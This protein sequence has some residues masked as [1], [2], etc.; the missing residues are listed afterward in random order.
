MESEQHGTEATTTE[1]GTAEVHDLSA[2][3]D[4]EQ[5][6]D[7]TSEDDTTGEAGAESPKNAKPVKF[8]DLAEA[9]GLEL[10]DLYKLEL[11][12]GDGETIT[13]EE[14]KALKG[15]QDDLTVRQLEIEEDHATKSADLRKAQN[16][17]AEI[18]A[19]LPEGSV[20][21][22]TL[23]KVRERQAAR[24]EIEQRKMLESIPSWSDADARAG[25]LAGMAQH[26][27]SFGFPPDHL[28]NVID[29]R[30]MVFVRESY[31]REQRIRKALE[32]VRAGAPNP[33]T[34][35]KAAKT[36]GKAKAAPKSRKG[37]ARNTL[38]AFFSDVE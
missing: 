35:T 12:V 19:A 11:N 29:H 33:T 1:S 3:L 8:N 26:L 20:N 37:D 30:L 4:L 22:K 14:L 24:V 34:S 15:E 16:E 23:E 17:L 6:N 36:G 9:T 38:E 5:P 13:V 25:D 7:T 2:L 31:K 32:R 28:S 18:V 10:D 27:E 21:A